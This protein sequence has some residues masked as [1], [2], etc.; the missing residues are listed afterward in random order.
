M[1]AEGGFFHRVKEAFKKPPV[2]EIPLEDVIK[3]PDT[4]K[5]HEIATSGFPEYI[6]ETAHFVLLPYVQAPHQVLLNASEVVVT[7][8]RLHISDD[9]DSPSLEI[10]EEAGG[11]YVPLPVILATGTFHDKKLRVQGIMQQDENSGAYSLEV[12]KTAEIVENKSS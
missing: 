8:H 12:K 11:L 7:T 5:D 1:K 6:G 3:Y 4:F 10:T 9:K 2:R